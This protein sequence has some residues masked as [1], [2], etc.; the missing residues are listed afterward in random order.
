MYGMIDFGRR[1]LLLL[2]LQSAK[3][4]QAG[5]VALTAKIYGSTTWNL[6]AQ[7]A[8]TRSLN[9]SGNMLGPGIAEK[10]AMNSVLQ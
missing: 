6:S 7:M 3:C 5:Q 10:A 4:K 8:I 9:L 2:Y 1:G